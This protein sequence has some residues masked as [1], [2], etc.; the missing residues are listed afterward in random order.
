MK[1]LLKERVRLTAA[2]RKGVDE[3]TARDLFVE[4]AR[5]MRALHAAGWEP[6][7]PEVEEFRNR[8]GLARAGARAG[9][10]ESSRRE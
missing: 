9:T 4:L 2:V 6:Y 10:T 7:V 3:A 1:G 5:T 8:A